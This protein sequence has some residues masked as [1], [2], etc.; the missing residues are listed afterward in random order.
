MNLWRTFMRIISNTVTILTDFGM[1]VKVIASSEIT[2]TSILND[3][4]DI[5]RCSV[6]EI[7][8]SYMA[9]LLLAFPYEIKKYITINF[10]IFNGNH[11]L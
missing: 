9:L 4:W 3:H 11:N 5:C 1:K 8:I 10:Q 6:R 7:K 2:T